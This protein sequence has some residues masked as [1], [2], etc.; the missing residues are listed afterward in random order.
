ML[1]VLTV[2]SVA[3]LSTKE[4][5]FSSGFTKGVT[6]SIT[7]IVLLSSFLVSCKKVLQILHI[8]PEATLLLGTKL[9]TI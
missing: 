3:I 4:V 1:G 7:D 2:A 8:S 6:A 5:K 9:L